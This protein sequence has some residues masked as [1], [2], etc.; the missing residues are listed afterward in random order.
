MEAFF[1][2]IILMSLGGILAI[3]AAWWLIKRAGR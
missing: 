2:T 3:A 1:I